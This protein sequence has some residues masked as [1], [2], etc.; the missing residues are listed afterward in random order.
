MPNYN[1]CPKC[2]KILTSVQ[3]EDITIDFGISKAWKG[4][5]HACPFCRHVL[6]VEINP[7]TLKEDIINGLFERLR[8][9]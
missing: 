9:N 1:K 5:S 2:E 4:F 7:L 8:R 6:S 3:T